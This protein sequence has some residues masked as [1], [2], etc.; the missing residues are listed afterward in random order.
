MKG[1]YGW[2]CLTVRRLTELLS[3][4]DDDVLI[5][6]DNRGLFIT[7]KKGD[8]LGSVVFSGSGELVNRPE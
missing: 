2:Q 3:L 8:Y 4:M 1:P 7:N 5:A 6:S